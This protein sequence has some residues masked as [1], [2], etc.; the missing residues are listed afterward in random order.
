MTGDIPNRGTIC[1][2]QSGLLGQD[3]GRPGQT[4][5]VLQAEEAKE[6]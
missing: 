1:C 5:E 6:K 4:E 2:S 3:H